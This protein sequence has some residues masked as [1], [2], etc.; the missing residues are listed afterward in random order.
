MNNITWQ[1][2]ITQDNIWK[3]FQLNF[4]DTTLIQRIKQ[5]IKQRITTQYNAISEN[6]SNLI[7]FTQRVSDEEDVRVNYWPNT[8]Q[9]QKQ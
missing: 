3:H 7:I 2:Y 1:R 4:F 8:S 9:D 5:R 6:I